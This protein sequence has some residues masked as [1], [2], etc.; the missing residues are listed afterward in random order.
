MPSLAGVCQRPQR[1]RLAV[2][3]PAPVSTEYA[4]ASST[5]TGSSSPTSGNP[6]WLVSPGG[7][8]NSF[9][10]YL[11]GTD[12]RAQQGLRSKCSAGVDEESHGATRAQEYRSRLFSV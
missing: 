2:F 3:V 4:I 9:G 1:L 7:A 11:R 6:G 10:W 8:A 5:E 12:R